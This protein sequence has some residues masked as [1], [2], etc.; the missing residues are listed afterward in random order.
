M[1]TQYRKI[2][3]RIH[4]DSYLKSWRRDPLYQYLLNIG[5][6]IWLPALSKVYG[7]DVF[8][9]DIMKVTF[10][11]SCEIDF[12][13]RWEELC[14]DNH[15]LHKKS[16][17]VQLK[18]F[19]YRHIKTGEYYLDELSRIDPSGENRKYILEFYKKEFERRHTVRM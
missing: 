12:Q 5:L 1:I 15:P 19:N 13:N 10:A 14:I 4:L 18:P 9:E 7:S 2:K 17:L 3:M 16:P 11:G 8:A 6:E